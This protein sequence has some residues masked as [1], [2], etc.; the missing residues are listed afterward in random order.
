MDLRCV[1][2]FATR[3]HGVVTM[4]AARRGGVSITG[5]Y[6]AHDRGLL[7]RL[8][9]GVSRVV[10]SPPTTLQRLT[11][12]VLAAGADALASHRTA[13]RLWGIPRP[14]TDPIDVILP[15]RQ[16]SSQ[17]REGIVVH[18]PRDR[19]DLAPADRASIPTTNVVRTLCDLGAVDPHAVPGAVGHVLSSRL[20]TVAALDRGIA[21]HSARG[22]AGVVAFRNALCH[23][24]L[25]GKPADSVLELAMGDLFHRFALPPFEFH[26]RIGGYEVDF[27]IVGTPILIECDGWTTHG[28]DRQAFDRDR[29]R[30]VAHT[31]AGFVTLRFTYSDIVRRPAA[32][33][34]AI[35]AALVRWAPH[36]LVA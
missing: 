14:E 2:S 1:E 25:D 9:P 17:Y 5:W 12:G 33:A 30:D 3:H 10:G 23:W 24:M 36:A 29:R 15:K 8:Y 16:R 28:L 27:H 19:K 20:A 34:R 6:R 31:A 35:R 7:E 21:R 32:T 26:P 18:R 11:A 22:R 13:A 4:A